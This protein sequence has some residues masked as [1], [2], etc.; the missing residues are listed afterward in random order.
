LE[1]SF[2]GKDGGGGGGGAIPVN[3]KEKKKGKKP[4]VK[5][6]KTPKIFVKKRGGEGKKP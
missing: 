2:H 4:W 5:W 1:E 3:G 6:V